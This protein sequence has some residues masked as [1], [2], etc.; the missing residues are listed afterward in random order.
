MKYVTQL[1]YIL[2]FSGL[3]ELLERVIPLPIPAAIYGLILLLIALCT[4][5]LKEE[6]IAD[7][8]DFLI[9]I[10]PVLFVAPAVKILQY[11]GLIAPN[12]AAICII[13]AVSTILVFIVSGLITKWIQGRK[14]GKDNG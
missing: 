8:A 4:G 5:L 12:L 1:L 9:A 14:G 6:K 11:W 7:S 3:G 13:I 10:M 2:L